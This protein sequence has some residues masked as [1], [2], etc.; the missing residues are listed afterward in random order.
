[1]PTN[2]YILTRI[3]A[4]ILCCV[5]EINGSVP[6]RRRNCA[7]GCVNQRDGLTYFRRNVLFVIYG[8]KKSCELYY[9]Y[10][11]R[12]GSQHNKGKGNIFNTF[13]MDNQNKIKIYTK[14]YSLTAAAFVLNKSP[15]TRAGH[16]W[17]FST[18]SIIIYDF[19]AFLSN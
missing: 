4:K 12:L 19:I 17:Y 7:G 15:N 5:L 6:L 10:T 13:S 18:F 3:L 8:I 1:M 11:H 14:G 16:F 2:M 9:G